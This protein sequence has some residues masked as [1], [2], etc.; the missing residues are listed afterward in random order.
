[1]K[2]NKK[3]LKKIFK[4]YAINNSFDLYNFKKEQEI[5]SKKF[6][7]DNE[8]DL[9][10]R[11]KFILLQKEITPGEAVKFS[12]EFLIESIRTFSKLYPLYCFSVSPQPLL[13]IDDY[14]ERFGT[15][16]L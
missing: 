2:R 3:E 6:N 8:D 9:L 1:L 12:D 5:V 11:M 7:F 13:L 15:S 4:E 14:T 10:N 16:F